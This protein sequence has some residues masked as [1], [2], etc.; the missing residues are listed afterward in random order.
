MLTIDGYR[1]LSIVPHVSKPTHIVYRGLKVW[2]YDNT[3]CCPLCG[4]TEYQYPDDVFAL[5]LLVHRAG[6]VPGNV[7][8]GH[9][10]CITADKQYGDTRYQSILVP[11]QIRTI[12]NARDELISYGN[13][14]AAGINACIQY[15]MNRRTY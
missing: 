14:H 11:S 13:V 7:F 1:R 5:G 12:W 15:R 8:I 6:Y 2:L 4:E 3:Q 9:A 10:S